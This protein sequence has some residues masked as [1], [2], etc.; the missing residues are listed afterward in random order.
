MH[1]R[2][3]ILLVCMENYVFFA[4]EV[5][6]PDLLFTYEALVYKVVSSLMF[7]IRNFI[8]QCLIKP[9]YGFRL[10]DYEDDCKESHDYLFL[11]PLC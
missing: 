6:Q 1:I 9:E 2:A 5:P 8:S 4:E 10:D 11:E 3:Y 7:C